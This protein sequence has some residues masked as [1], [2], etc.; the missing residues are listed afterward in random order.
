M[1]WHGNVITGLRFKMTMDVI[2]TFFCK[3]V[4]GYHLR[5]HNFSPN[6][7]DI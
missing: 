2:N 3:E 5:Q 1:S 6:S 4:V 7:Q